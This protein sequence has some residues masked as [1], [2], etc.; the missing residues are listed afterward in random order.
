MNNGLQWAKSDFPNQDD[1]VRPFFISY[2]RKFSVSKL[3]FKIVKVNG[4][5]MKICLI[6]K[7]KQSFTYIFYYSFRTAVC[8]KIIKKPRLVLQTQYNKSRPKL[9]ALKWLI[10]MVS[11]LSQE[12]RYEL[13]SLTTLH[14][15]VSCIFLVR[16]LFW[17]YKALNKNNFILKQWPEDVRS[18]LI[19]SQVN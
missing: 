8:Y 16:L 4:L 18:Y 10:T 12:P 15:F 14:I 6:W 9:F 17:E 11:S 5:I 3:V 7:L 2:N 19:I 1:K 13:Q